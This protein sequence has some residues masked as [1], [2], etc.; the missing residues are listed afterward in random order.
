MSKE[1]V[2]P[3]TPKAL[4]ALCHGDKFY[5]EGVFQG[6]T[7]KQVRWQVAGGTAKA[8]TVHASYLGIFL[9]TFKLGIKNGKVILNAQKG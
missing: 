4:E 6:V 7:P 3:G 8:V 5:S 9:G 1:V 2:F